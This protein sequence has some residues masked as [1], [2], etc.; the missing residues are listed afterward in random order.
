MVL[1]KKISFFLFLFSGCSNLKSNHDNDSDNILN[2][3][4]LAS[5]LIISNW[6]YDSSGCNHLRT[7]ENG[8]ALTKK[9]NL[10]SKNLDGIIFKTST[11]TFKDL[12]ERERARAADGV[13][14]LV[15]GIWKN[16]DTRISDLQ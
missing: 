3:K 12:Q 11:S 8:F 9:Y 7:Y 13:R 4:S 10:E 1:L 14:C 5:D 16:P 2:K 6:K 15:S